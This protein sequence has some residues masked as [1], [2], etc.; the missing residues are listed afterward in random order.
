MEL[1]CPKVKKEINRRLLSASYSWSVAVSAEHHPVRHF[2]TLKGRSG[3]CRE[4][5]ANN[6]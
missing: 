6:T 3:G 4:G 1:I 5:I 2:P